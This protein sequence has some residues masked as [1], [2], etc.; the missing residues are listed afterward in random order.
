VT[1]IDETA[2]TAP[3]Y[4][5]PPT[6]VD[7][8]V[9]SELHRLITEH[10]WILDRGNILDLPGL[11][12]D[13]GVLLGLE[14]PLQGRDQIQAWSQKR[15]ALTTRTSR[16]VHANVR[17][18]HVAEDVVHGT[19]V[20][21]LFRHEGNGLGSSTP[22]SV[23]DYDDTYQRVEGRWLLRRR[24][25]TRVFVDGTRIPAAP[26]S[27]PPPP[28]DSSIIAEPRV[29]AMAEL[30]REQIRENLSRV[31]VRSDGAIV[32]FNWFEPGFVSK[33]PHSHPFDQ[34]S[35]VFGGELEFTV[36]GVSYLVPSGSVLRIPAGLEHSAQPRG[37]DQVLN[38]DVFAPVRADYEYLTAYQDAEAAL[39]TRAAFMAE[40]AR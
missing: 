37:E 1:A 8:A 39:D 4:S 13:D 31:A 28:V 26:A 24:E 18:Q 3:P 9:E 25:M 11:Y 35:F 19:L 36:A 23:S 10:A 2:R 17:F 16:H 34:L 22:L 5:G 38:V 33:G 7:P 32:T 15:A 12:T 20:T 30:P 29:Y 40:A 21:L 27:A 14:Q 6:A